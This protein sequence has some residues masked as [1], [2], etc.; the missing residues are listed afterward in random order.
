LLIF[1]I[2]IAVFAVQNAGPVNISIFFW[3]MRVPLVFVIFGTALFGLLAGLLIG[4]FS[5]RKRAGRSGRYSG[6]DT[7]VL[8]KL[9]K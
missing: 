4:R 5:G 2:L 1:A 7:A 8:D 9:D 3:Q 6:D